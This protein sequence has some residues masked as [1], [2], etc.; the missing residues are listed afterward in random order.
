MYTATTVEE[1]NEIRLT[2]RDS[3][4]EGLLFLELKQLPPERV[5]DLIGETLQSV[6]LEKTLQILAYPTEQLIEGG[7]AAFLARVMGVFDVAESLLAE[8]MGAELSLPPLGVSE[9]EMP[10][11]D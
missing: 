7:A 2:A 5:A 8:V 11:V 1:F 3:A 9:S 6:L 10:D 4:Q